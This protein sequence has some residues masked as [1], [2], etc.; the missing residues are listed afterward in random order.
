MASIMKKNSSKAPP[1]V[2]VMYI[3]IY[4]YPSQKQRIYTTL[5]S[6]IA[7]RTQKP[8]SS[9]TMKP[10]PDETLSVGGLRQWQGRLDALDGLRWFASLQVVFSHQ[11][12]FVP[13]LLWG[14]WP[15]KRLTLIEPFEICW[16]CEN[17][18]MFFSRH[19]F[20]CFFVAFEIW[21]LQ[22]SISFYVWL[23]AQNFWTQACCTASNH[24]PN[25]TH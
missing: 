10:I 24:A 17:N 6:L 18:N 14:N 20:D 19:V 25:H 7:I 22:N 2:R 9:G 15:T 21:I 11:A 4:I 8:W 5:Q 13:Y 16:G 12:K 3:Y 23:K 1:V